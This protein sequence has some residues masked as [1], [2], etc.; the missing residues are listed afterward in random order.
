MENGDVQL[1]QK[2]RDIRKGKKMTIN[3][4]AKQTGFTPSFISQLERGLTKASVSSLQKITRAL[5]ITLS[6]LFNSADEIQTTN[7]STN[8]IRKKERSKLVF[9]DEKSTD[10][11]LTGIDGRFEVILTEMEPG[12]ESGELISH[13]EGEEAITVLEGTVEVTVG[14]E[15]YILEEGDTITFASQVP[16]GWSNVG[17]SKLKLIWVVSPPTY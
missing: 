3:E 2:I 5:D 17:D 1:G 8:L 4:V 14:N 7:Q 15:Q 12:G 13:D 11:L 9:P 6:S 16:H 10:Y